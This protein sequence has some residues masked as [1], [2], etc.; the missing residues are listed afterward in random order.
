MMQMSGR[1]RVWGSSL[2]L[3][4]FTSMSLGVCAAVVSALDGKLPCCPDLASGK[5]SFTACCSTGDQS[6]S[7]DLHVGVQTLSSPTWEIVFAVASSIS[8]LDLSRRRSF[9]AI[10][11]RSADSQALLSTFLI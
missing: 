5:P 8:P 3:V 4:L 11:Y 7:S 1:R 9:A 2:L 10:P 6:P